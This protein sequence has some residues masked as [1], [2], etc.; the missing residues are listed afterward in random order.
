MSR[1]DL[2]GWR[3]ETRKSSY[4]KQKVQNGKSNFLHIQVNLNM[5]F[6]SVLVLLKK[7]ESAAQNETQVQ[8]LDLHLFLMMVHISDE[9]TESPM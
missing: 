8:H 3:V 2:K 9:N 4:V 5:M 1:K 6:L 7:K